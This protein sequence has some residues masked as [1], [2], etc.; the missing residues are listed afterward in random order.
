MPD[1]PTG[2]ELFVVLPFPSSPWKLFP[3]QSTVPFESSAQASSPP[4][5]MA[6]AVDMPDA[7]TGIEL[8]VVLPFPRLP[9]LLFPQHC[10]EPFASNAQGPAVPTDMEVAVDMP[11]TSTGIGLFVVV[12]FP[13]WPKALFPQHATEP[14]ENKAQAK[15]EPAAI[16]FTLQAPL[17]DCV[18]MQD[19]GVPLLPVQLQPQPI[20]VVATAE[21]V[22]L[23][24]RFAVGVPVA[25]VPFAEPQI[26]F[27]AASGALHDAVVPLFVPAQVHV[28]GPVPEMADAVPVVQR[29]VVGALV[30]ATVFAEPHTPGVQAGGAVP[31]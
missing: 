29:L 28:S 16:C 5:D 3:Q 10:T 30:T 14:F 22:P 11:E 2:V 7:L 25:T 21:A 23:V 17:A 26:P 31:L 18:A 15:V 1:A 13:S 4:A 24:Q 27:M 8:F 6:V 9:E 12:P 20:E 19:A